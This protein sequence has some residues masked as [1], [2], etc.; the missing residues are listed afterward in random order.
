LTGARALFSRFRSIVQRKRSLADQFGMY[1]GGLTGAH[2][3]RNL[4]PGLVE[5]R[6]SRGV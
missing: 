2:P 6:L 3:E 4:V 5:R 1:L